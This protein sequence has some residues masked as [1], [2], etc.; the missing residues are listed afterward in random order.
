MSKGEGPRQKWKEQSSIS[1]RPCFEDAHAQ[2]KACTCSTGSVHMLNWKCAHA[3][4]EPFLER[5][6][7]LL[8]AADNL[9]LMY[10]FQRVKDLVKMSLGDAFNDRKRNEQ[11]LTSMRPCFEDVHMHNW[12]RAYAQ[13]GACTCSTKSVCMLTRNCSW[14][15]PSLGKVRPAAWC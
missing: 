10:K 13:L 4:Q 8:S 15:V 9:M 3:H 12:K 14:N 11:S 5:S 7:T 1:R 6:V 2:V